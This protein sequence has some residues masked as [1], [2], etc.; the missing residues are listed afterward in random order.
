VACGPARLTIGVPFDE[1]ASPPGTALTVDALEGAQDPRARRVAAALELRRRDLEPYERDDLKRIEAI[2][3]RLLADQREVEVLNYGA[4]SRDAPRAASEMERG[5]ITR[6]V[7][8]EACKRASSRRRKAMVLYG[9]VRQLAPNHALELG[10]FVGIS[11]AYQAMGL[12]HAA[13]RG[14][15]RRRPVGRL[16]TLEGA[17]AWAAIAEETF[18]SAGLD[19]VDVVVGRFADTLPSVLA[20]QHF[21]YAFIDGHHDEEATLDYFE[22]IVPRADGGVLVVDDI[23][24]NKCMERAWARI[25]ADERVGLAVDLGHYG[26]VHVT[27]AR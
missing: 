22:R 26:I 6:D 7:V 16:I 3:E 14:L 9:L 20:G 18:A 8:G 24:W 11:G 4:G 2:R 13:P 12:R 17:P 5:W 21:G 27:A 19:N 10:T 15:L 23:R 25:V 1:P